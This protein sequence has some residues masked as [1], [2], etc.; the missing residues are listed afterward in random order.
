MAVRIVI[1]TNTVMHATIMGMMMV[2]GAERAWI[3]V[4]V[5]IAVIPV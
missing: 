5:P 4:V 2:R 3:V 1:T